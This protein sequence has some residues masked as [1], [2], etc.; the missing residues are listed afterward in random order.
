VTYWIGVI[1]RKA[2]ILSYQDDREQSHSTAAQL[3]TRKKRNRRSKGK[4]TKEQSQTDCDQNIKDKL[5]LING[6]RNRRMKGF[7]SLKEKGSNILY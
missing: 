1:W 2:D 3:V 7:L 6:A 5:F 4:A